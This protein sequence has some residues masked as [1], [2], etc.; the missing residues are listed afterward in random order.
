MTHETTEN[1]KLTAAIAY[2]RLGWQ[3]LPLHTI[4]GDRH[5]RHCSCGKIKCESAGKHPNGDLAPHGV[6]DATADE[7]TI[8]RWWTAEPDANIGIATGK[9]SGIF[10]ADTDMR[11]GGDASWTLLLQAH[12]PPPQT[13]HVLTG[14]GGDH[15]YYQY[16]T[17]GS[18][19]NCKL[20][21]GIDI[22]NDALTLTLS[23]WE[24]E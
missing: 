22:V 6:A 24:R 19:A 23:P 20:T 15:Y 5:H 18:V 4:R 16:P 3:V 14:G 13:P 17:S 10:V 1:P 8:R 21:Q 11:N 12:G 9:Q 7:A 2:T